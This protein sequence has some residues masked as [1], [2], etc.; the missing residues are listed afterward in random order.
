MEK[1]Y[2]DT[3]IFMDLLSDN[4]EFARKALAYLQRIKS[5]E[6]GGVISSILFAELAFHIRRRHDAEKAEEIIYCIES[7]P[8]VS[9]IRV[10][11]EIAKSAGMIRARYLRKIPKRL[12]YF[13]CIHLATAMREGCSRFVT[14]DKGF[15]DIKE[16]AVEIY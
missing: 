1:I 2:L 7:L 14:G 6:C 8:N 9:V 13:D 5:G 10:D 3:F 15:R 16:I 4:P 12:T 11:G